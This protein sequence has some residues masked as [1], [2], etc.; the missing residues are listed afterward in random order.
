MIEEMK[1]LR[2]TGTWELTMLPKGK[3]NVG[4]KWVYTV[5]HRADGS[6]ERYKARLVAKGFTQTY[7]VDYEETFAPVAKMNSIRILLSLAANLDWPLHQFDVKNDFLHGDLEK[8]VY[9]DVPPSFENSKTEGKVCRLKKSLYGFKQ[10]PRAWFE[11]FTQAM[12]RFGFRQSHAD[13]TLFIK[14]SLGG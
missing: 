4:Y 1:A 14:H 3:R 13:H 12:L 7:G 10:S 8:E 5:K 2:K 6:I 9:M 11:L